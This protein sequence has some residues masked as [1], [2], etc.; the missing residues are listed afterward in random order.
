MPAPY[1]Y[2]EQPTAHSKQAQ[3]LVQRKMGWNSKGRE[4]Q[5]VLRQ[6]SETINIH[7]AHGFSHASPQ[8]LGEGLYGMNKLYIDMWICVCMLL[9]KHST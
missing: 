7:P 6:G 8:R 4:E 5:A 2:T 3:R 9:N 1:R